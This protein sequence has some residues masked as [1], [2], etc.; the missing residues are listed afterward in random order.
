MDPALAHQL[1]PYRRFRHVV[2]HGYGFQIEWDRMREGLDQVGQVLRA[3]R[4]RTETHLAS[5]TRPD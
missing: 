3:F 2:Y 1:G 5:L 4:D